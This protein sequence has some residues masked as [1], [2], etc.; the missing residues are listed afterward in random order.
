MEHDSPEIGAQVGV[1]PTTSDQSSVLANLFQLYAHDFSEFHDVD[2]GG[3]AATAAMAWALKQPGQIWRRF[4]GHW[5]IRVM[6]SNK[7]ACHFWARAIKTV[8]GKVIS[9]IRVEIASR[10]W[11]VFSFDSVQAR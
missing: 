6:E 2:I 9:P 10:F 5:E 4:P 3:F 8:L 1:V 11:Y 7:A